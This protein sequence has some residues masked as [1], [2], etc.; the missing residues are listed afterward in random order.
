MSY[1][2]RNTIDTDGERRTTH[3]LTTEAFAAVADARRRV[4]LDVLTDRLTLHEQDLAARVAARERA[5]P[6]SDV[7]EAEH[8]QVWIS[9]HHCHLPKLADLGFVTRVDDEVRLDDDAPDVEALGLLEVPDGTCGDPTDPAD[10]LY[11]ALASD[12]RRAVLTVLEVRTA[13]PTTDADALSVSELA[14]AVA[15]EFDGAVDVAADPSRVELTLLHRDLPKLAETGLV[16]YDREAG[17]VAFVG[18]PLL[19]SAWLAAAPT[20]EPSTSR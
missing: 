1:R 13:P 12:K 2:V 16:D 15:A 8:Q 5:K 14:E 19:K 6:V 7:T 18:H 3:R 4:V 20:L 11:D 9:L 17:R 10:A